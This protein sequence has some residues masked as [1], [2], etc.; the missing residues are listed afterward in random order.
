MS[1]RLAEIALLIGSPV[2]SNDSI[3]HRQFA[4]TA[5]PTFDFQE[6]IVGPP[7]L[8]KT[9]FHMSKRL[10]ESTFLDSFN[11]AFNRLT[12]ASPPQWQFAPTPSPPFNFPG[13]VVGPQGL[14]IMVSYMADRLAEIALLI[15]LTVLSNDSNSHRQF[16]PIAHG[17]FDSQRS[18]VGPQGLDIIVFYMF[19]RLA[20]SALMIG[21]M[22]LSIATNSHR[23]RSGNSSLHP[24]HPSNFEEAS[25]DLRGLT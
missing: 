21:L 18:V 25:S 22:V 6:S 10:S 12:F 7:D 20:E 9:V 19:Q 11:G 16:A 15:A 2:L 13:S 5:S 17:P 14:D 1:R 23:Q 24:P 4:P 8:A 3:S